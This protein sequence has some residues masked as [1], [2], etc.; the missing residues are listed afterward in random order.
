MNHPHVAKVLDGGLTPQGRPYF[1]MEYVKGEPITD[2]C[3]RQKLSIKDRL[4]LFTQVCEAVQHAH[5]KGIIHRD[6]K[7]GNVLVAMGDGGAPQAKV[8]DFG[9][10]KAL[11]QRMS[12]HTIFTET[13][14]MIGT[15]LYMSPE[16]AEPDANDIDTRSDVYSLGVVLYELLTGALPFDPKE[17]RSKAY[18]EVQ[19]IIREED[20][21][22]PSARLSTIATKDT[23]LASKIAEARKDAVANL[24][25]LLKTELE[26]IPLKAMHKDRKERY[27]S[28][29]DFARDVQNYLEGRPLVAAPESTAY[30]VRKYIRR[31]RGFVIGATTVLAALVLGLG[32]AT[33]QWRAA[34]R[35]RD[36][37]IAAKDAEKERADQLK[38]VSDFQSQMLSQIDTTQAGI[39]LMADVRER[40]VAA[41]EKAGVAE[42][43]RTTRLD[44]L[45]QELVRVNATDAAAAMIDRTILKPAI[46]TIDTQFKDDPAT[47]A[48]LRQALAD[49]YRSI[50]LYDAAYP[51]QE[52]ALATRRRVLGEEHPD[53]LRS[54]GNMGSLLQRQGKFAEAEPYYRDAL[55]KHRRVLGEEHPDTLIAINNMGSLLQSQGKPAEAEPY[56]RDALEKS[57][58]VLGEEHPDT[59]ISISYMGILLQSQG[60]FTEA[61]PYYRDA[62]EK[63]R[64]VLGEEHAD[65]LTFINNMGY[66]LQGQ[67]KLAEAEPYYRDALEKRRRVLGEEHPDTL[68]ANNNM[69]SLL[70]RQGKFAEAE[71]YWRD[72]LE[73]HR[74]VLGEEH[75]NTLIVINN[76]GILL[77]SQGKFAE[78]EPYWRDALEKRRRVLGEEHPD[79]LTASNNMGS[80]L[81]SQGK[82]AEA[83]PYLRDAL[84]KS[85]RVLGEEHPDTLISIN[86]MGFLLQSQGKFAEAEPYYRD[87]LEKRRRVLGEEHPDTLNSVSLIGRLHLAQSKDREALDLAEPFEPAARKAFSGGNAPRL[88]TFLTLLGRARVGV[89]YDRA[90]FALAEA[91]LLE[92]HAIFLAAKNRGPSHK[93]TLECV[94]ALIDLY[95]AWD[96]AEPGKGYAAKAAELKAS[97]DAAKPPEPAAPAP[98]KK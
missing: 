17:L 65:T 98:D 38:K 71:P 6:L 76:M 93:D 43:D 74:R 81:Q 47:D 14:Q 96:K 42:A 11:T 18:R 88:A 58:R 20:P 1:A 73:K 10:A 87:A 3:D 84:E 27:D 48:S 28:P 16:Q 50:G 39:D 4:R 12:E 33:W 25:R 90:R 72:A 55:E 66:L 46:K 60:K 95:T 51:L 54:I 67:G 97:L 7:P 77:Q 94:K 53:T 35:A 89:G 64:R 22:T 68:I 59:L 13:G 29:A 80:L 78:A 26:W 86:N 9:V 30:R 44:A 56:W 61:E 32:L 8:I 49:L 45:R 62:L 5:T 70:Q 41:L 57:R 82:P 2:F 75:P 21:P 69:G 91:N 15:P 79:T 19:R 85:R 40:F 23:A 83:E 63:S 37:A 34:N 36:E 31:H 92:A 24:S 52:S